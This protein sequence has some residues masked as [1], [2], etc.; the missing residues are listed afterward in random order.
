[1]KAK[2][3]KMDVHDLR[4]LRL[5]DAIEQKR[6]PSQR[7]LAR[8]LGVSLG[9]VNSFVRRLAKKGYFKITHLPRNRIRY[10]LTPKGAAEKTRLTYAYL[11]FSYQFYREARSKLRALFQALSSGKVRSVAF[12]GAGDLAEIA[13]LS[14]Q[15]TNLQ[16]VGIG[17]TNSN[18]NHFFG[19]P[20]FDMNAFGNLQF[21]AVIVTHDRADAEILEPLKTVGISADKIKTL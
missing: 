18:H 16:F 14:L 5:L 2:I 15:E 7:D 21:D 3:D 8:V 17:D 1:M 9:L 12:F 4:T 19:H 10:I 13:Y 6:S 11:Q 20:V